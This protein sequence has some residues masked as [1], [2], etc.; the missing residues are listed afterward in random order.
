MISDGGTFLGKNCRS[1]PM[2]CDGVS[3]HQRY[4]E[5]VGQG[6][7]REAQLQPWLCGFI[8]AWVLNQSQLALGRR[9]VVPLSVW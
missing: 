9:A 7:R 1:Q 5:L 2:A 4:A 6:H 8:M 3:A